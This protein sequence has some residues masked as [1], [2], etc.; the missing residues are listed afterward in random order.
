MACAFGGTFAEELGIRGGSVH[1]ACCTQRALCEREASD[2]KSTQARIEPGDGDG[3][4]QAKTWNTECKDEP[5]SPRP[6]PRLFRTLRTWPKRV[7]RPRR[8]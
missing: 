8:A 1:R 5:P 4:E 2:Q 7:P 3:D 6:D